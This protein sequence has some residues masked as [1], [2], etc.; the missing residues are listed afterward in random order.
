MKRQFAVLAELKIMAKGV[1]I[2]KKPNFTARIRKK[3][4][5][6]LICACVLFLLLIFIYR[7]TG[8]NEFAPALSNKALGGWIAAAMLSF[9]LLIWENKALTYVAYLCGLYAWLQFLTSQIYYIVNVFV[10]ID[11]SS[12]SASFIF[13]A[14]AGLAAWIMALSAAIRRPSVFA[15]GNNVQKEGA[16]EK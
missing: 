7:E 4:F 10:A 1:K 15:N 2:M 13:T 8:K 6:P 12:F 14:A 16:E 5:I 9:V 11:G 3:G